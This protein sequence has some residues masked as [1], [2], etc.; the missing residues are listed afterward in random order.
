MRGRD[1]VELGVR[2]GKGLEWKRIGIP[3]RMLALTVASSPYNEGP[4]K[5]IETQGMNS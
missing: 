4:T 1:R 5:L 3:W 2:I